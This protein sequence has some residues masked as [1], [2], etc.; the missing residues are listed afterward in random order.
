MQKNWYAV[1]TKPHCERKVSLLLTR[2]GIESFCP[3]NNK[4]TEHLFYNKV[5]QEPVFKSTVFVRTT[6]T[7]IVS[8]NKR[9]DYILNPLFLRKEPAIINVDEIE[10]IKEFTDNYREIGFEKLDLN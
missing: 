5:F 4:R 7:D 9:I 3:L 8:L 10:A 2:K 6:A 1:Y